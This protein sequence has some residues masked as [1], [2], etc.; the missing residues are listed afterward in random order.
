MDRLD[1]FDIVIRRRD[2]KVTAAVPQ[3]SLYSTAA[4]LNGA[5]EGLERKKAELV[6]ELTEVDDL[7]SLARVPLAAPAAAAGWARSDSLG[8]FTIKVA[9]VVALV[10]VA[11]L[12]S[13]NLVGA[14]IE[15]LVY[16]ARTDMQTLLDQY[17]RI[18]GPQFWAKMEYNLEEMANPG[19]QLSEAKK[20]KL[21]TN[22]RVI[23]ERWWPLVEAA[24]APPGDARGPDRDGQKSDK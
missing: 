8:R 21:L 13:A 6:K 2:N 18:G 9:I 5:L 4:D 16:R 7:D 24:L 10:A 14:E 19:N 15:R 1:E 22:I 17:T 23:K 20:Q 3:L 12:G 11:V